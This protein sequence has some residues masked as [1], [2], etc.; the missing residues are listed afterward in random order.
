VEVAEATPSDLPR[1]LVKV[2]SKC[3]PS[4]GGNNVR[5]LDIEGRLWGAN[6]LVRHN[7]VQHEGRNWA[8]EITGPYCVGICSFADHMAPLKAWPLGDRFG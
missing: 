3:D 1:G 4:E 6:I 7:N 8:V 2:G 5:D